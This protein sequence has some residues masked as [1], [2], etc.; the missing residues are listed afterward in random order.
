[1]ESNGHEVVG[2]DINSDW[3]SRS[4]TVSKCDKTDAVHG[5]M[6][7]SGYEAVDCRIVAILSRKSSKIMSCELG[8]KRLLRWFC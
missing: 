8:S 1:M 7:G 5:C 6:V 2:T 3:I 4:V